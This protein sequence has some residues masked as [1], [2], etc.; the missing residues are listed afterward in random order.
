MRFGPE[1]L[2]R[3]WTDG[4][5]YDMKIFDGQMSIRRKGKI[6]GCSNKCR[7]CFRVSLPEHAA[8]PQIREP[9]VTISIINHF[10]PKYAYQNR[11]KSTMFY[12]EIHAYL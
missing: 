9:H 6:D 11:V 5:M 12:G 3:C 7:T 4:D 1:G 10:S 8:T 2:R